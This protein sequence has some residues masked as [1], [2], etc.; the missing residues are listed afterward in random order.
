MIGC[1][2]EPIDRTGVLLLRLWIEGGVSTGFRAR[3]TQTLDGKSREWAV[4]SAATAEATYAI[5]QR[6]VEA[7]IDPN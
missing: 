5:I 7:F 2:S 3:I 6:W 1:M 4:A